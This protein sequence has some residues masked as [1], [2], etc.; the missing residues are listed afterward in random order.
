[1]ILVGNPPFED[2]GSG[3]GNPHGLD[4][5]QEQHFTYVHVHSNEFE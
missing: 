1:M 3:Y 4:A 5:V 2:S